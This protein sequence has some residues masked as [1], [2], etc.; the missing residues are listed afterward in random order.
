MAR[1]KQTHKDEQLEL[2]DIQKRELELR[3]K[4]IAAAKERLAMEREE[5]E[6]TLPPTE[7]ILQRE[8]LR[9]HN[10]RV[11]R[12]EYKNYSRAQTGSVLI[13]VLLLTATGTLIWWGLSL[14]GGTTP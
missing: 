9:R 8:T 14:M 2:I 11:T 5:Q 1:K 12:S 7:D 13:L 4:T 6:R 3:A 10:E